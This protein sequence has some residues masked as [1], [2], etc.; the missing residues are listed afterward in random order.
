MLS[1]KEQHRRQR[2]FE[3]TIKVDFTITGIAI[4]GGKQ[5][6]YKRNFRN[7]P[8]FD[9]W[10]SLRKPELEILEVAIGTFNIWK[11]GFDSI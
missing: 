8:E 2:I 7:K 6:V 10:L 9:I 4:D 1:L 11:K 3:S 5:V